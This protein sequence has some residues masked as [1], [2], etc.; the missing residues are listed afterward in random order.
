MK[1]IVEISHVI[2]VLGDGN[3]IHDHGHDRDDQGDAERLE[4]RTDQH[5]NDQKNHP[6]PLGVI[7]QHIDLL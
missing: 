3:R 4:E 5:E 2:L 6:D 1:R 7:Q